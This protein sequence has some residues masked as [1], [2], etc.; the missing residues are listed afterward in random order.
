MKFRCFSALILLGII[1][2][3][4]LA[5]FTIGSA[6]DPESLE[7]LENW[8]EEEEDVDKNETTFVA[9]FFLR[10]TFFGIVL[11]SALFHCSNALFLEIVNTFESIRI[12]TS[13]P[14]PKMS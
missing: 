8:S 1:L 12:E 9:D 11:E 13:T 14:P 6:E 10:D 3:P 2:I 5:V 7:L 4:L